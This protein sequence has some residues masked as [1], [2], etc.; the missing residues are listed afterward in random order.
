[1][2][3]VSFVYQEINKSSE[4]I[5]QPILDFQYGYASNLYDSCES[6][7]FVSF[8]TNKLLL[9]FFLISIALI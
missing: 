4:I 7:K 6:V 1:M 2:K 9:F 8:I 3:L 5:T